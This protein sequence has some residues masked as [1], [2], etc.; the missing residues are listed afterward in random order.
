[1]DERTNIVMPMLMSISNGRRDIH[2]LFRLLL[3]LLNFLEKEK[4]F[5]HESNMS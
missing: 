1:M 4:R 2:L 3:H 5:E